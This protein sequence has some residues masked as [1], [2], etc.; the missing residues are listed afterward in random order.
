VAQEA[1]LRQ[2]VEE[3]LEARAAAQAELRHAMMFKFVKLKSG[4]LKKLH[5]RMKS[6]QRIKPML[7]R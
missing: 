3:E 1:A 7:L 6:G 2:A 4:E 5:Q